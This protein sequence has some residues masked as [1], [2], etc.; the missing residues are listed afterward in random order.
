MEIIIV[1]IIFFFLMG[2]LS[3]LGFCIEYDDTKT[4]RRFKYATIFCLVAEVISMALLV[5][6][7]I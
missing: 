3:L 4:K 6:F 2:A 5:I 7:S 1:S